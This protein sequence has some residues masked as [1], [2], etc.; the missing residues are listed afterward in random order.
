MQI[1]SD[2][3]EDR[4]MQILHAIFARV[5]VLSNITNENVSNFSV[6]IAKRKRFIGVVGIRHIV[7]SNVNKIIGTKNTK[8]AA[9][10]K[11]NGMKID[12]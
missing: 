10:G 3:L 9:D 2:Q 12:R 11:D 8:K 1:I 7:R 4:E 5:I 6:L